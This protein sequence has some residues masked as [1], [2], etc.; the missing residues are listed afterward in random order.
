MKNI[1]YYVLA[2]VLVL[3]MMGGAYAAWEDELAVEGEVETGEMDVQ[4]TDVELTPTEDEVAEVKEDAE[5]SEDGKEITFSIENA[6]PDYEYDV[7]FTFENKGTIPINA[8]IDISEVSD[9]PF[10][11]SG[12]TIASNITYD[13]I[14]P[15]ESQTFS[16]GQRIQE[17][18]DEDEK[19]EY[20]ISI[21]AIQWN[22]D[23]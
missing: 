12:M 20:T 23:F 9:G 22:V 14:A 7:E 18:A 5:I 3:G 1:K 21:D 15:N 4:F 19:Y 6:Y 8:K 11:I 16:Y 17:D 10:V 2:L 13:D